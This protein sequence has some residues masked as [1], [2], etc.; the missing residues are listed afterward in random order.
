MASGACKN[1][2]CLMPV[3]NMFLAG[4]LAGLSYISTFSHIAYKL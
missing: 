4:G 2:S 1:T 3:T